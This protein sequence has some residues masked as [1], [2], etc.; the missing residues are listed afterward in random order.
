MLYRIR[1]YYNKLLHNILG[2]WKYFLYDEKNQE[3]N[4]LRRY[5]KQQP[6]TTPTSKIAIFVANGYCNHAGLCDRLKG[7]T[8]LYGWCKEYNIDFRIYHINPFNL[9]DYLIP[10]EY[11]WEIKEGD[12]CYN[13]KWTSANHLMLNNLVRKQIESGE[14][15]TLEKEWFCKRI[16]TRKKQMHFYTNM[17]PENDTQFGTYFRM[18]FKPSPRLEDALNHHLSS[19]GEPYISVSF[20]FVQLLGDF[21]DCDGAILSLENQE[22][23]IQRSIKVIEEIKEINQ[24]YS[25]I[26]ITADS[27]KFLEEARMLPYVYI[28]EG[29]VGHIN[30]ENSDDVNMKTF[31]DFLLISKAEKV[32]LAKSK[33]MY[34]S[35]FARR[36]A[37][38]YNHPFELFN[39]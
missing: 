5:Y 35:D 20:R 12:I 10:N 8:T 37:M 11:N 30:F 1:Y 33:D 29:E 36:A 3:N 26:L 13:R 21:K 4:V 14:I 23:L 15:A 6:H 19:I 32:Y 28:V 31:L 25:I 34:N 22:S 18:L 9:A 17:Y 16:K 2:D 7:I 38:I 39:F 27:R 24:S